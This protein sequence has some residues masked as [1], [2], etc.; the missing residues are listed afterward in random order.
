MDHYITYSGPIDKDLVRELADNG[1]TGFRLIFKGISCAKMQES[2]LLL[3]ENLPGSCK[4]MIDLPGTKPRIGQ[5]GEAFTVN[6]GDIFFLTNATQER[7]ESSL[8]VSNI[9]REQFAK[10][11]P[12]HRVW[13]GDGVVQAVVDQS[14]LTSLECRCVGGKGRLS[15]GRSIVFPDSDIRNEALSL[16][17]MEFL[18]SFANLNS[19][20]EIAVS[21]VDNSCVL[22]RVHPLLSKTGTKLVAKIES[23]VP[24]DTLIEIA[25]QCDKL[26]LGR[27]DL[28]MSTSGHGFFEYQQQFIS[29]CRDRKKSFMIA[30]GLL[31]SLAHANRPTIA[32]CTDIGFLLSQGVTSFLI[33]DEVSVFQPKRAL[34]ALRA[35]ASPE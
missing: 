21:F 19:I 11:Q 25:N 22:P 23:P 33:A 26:L 15:S 27:G 28:S 34:R 29:F 6:P 10:I 13:I 30:T 20:E 9:S 24:M 8:P 7:S 35:L 5:I 2:V 4:I 12:T 14:E 31:S 1:C 17:D 16:A 32:E 3:R 18:R